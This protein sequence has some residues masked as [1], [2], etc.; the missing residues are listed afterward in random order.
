VTQVG[1]GHGAESR[2]V[3]TFGA[4][5]VGEILA[6]RYQL[7]EHINNDATGRQVWRGV[8][9]ILRRPVAVVLRYP[10]GEAAVEMLDAAVAAS[11]VTH[12]N[13]VGVY[14]AIDEGDRAYV[15]REWVDGAAL[16]DYVAQTP[17]DAAR[18][19]TVAHAV[20]AA[21][22]AVHSTGMVHGN[23]H[24]GTVLIG[25]DGRVVLADARAEGDLDPEQDIRATGAVLY[26][27]LTGH[28]PQVEAGRQKLPDAVRDANGMLASPRRVRA[29]VPTY[30]DELVT[31]LLDLRVAAPSADLLAAELGRLDA[32]S[33][34]DGALEP[35][36][37]DDQESPLGF[38]A[39]P[40]AEPPRRA[41]RKVAIGVIALLLVAAVGLYVG[42]RFL[43]AT[44]ADGSPTTNGQP[45]AG[46][47]QTAAAGSEVIKLSADQVR[48]VDPGGDRTELGGVSAAIDGNL[49]T[50]W[51][52]QRYR[53]NPKFGGLK[54]GMG[55][56]INLKE[57]RKVSVE[58]TLSAPGASA[59][60]RTGTA[61][62]PPTKAGD[63]Q[64]VAAYQVGTV[65]PTELTNHGIKMVFEVSDPAQ[66]LLFWITSMPKADDGQYQIG[67]QEIVLHAR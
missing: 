41:G 11:R 35:G 13:L 16:R 36:Y 44:G 53:N 8:D 66:Y 2:P 17:L 58:I 9:V 59:Q 43:T 30:L 39:I 47:N 64:I 57:P 5:A 28:W 3:M 51:K 32:Q 56:L 52:T 12:S 34:V 19:T 54:P 22:A 26:F 7:E 55:I 60:L 37:Y 6:D 61:D 10:G 29:G 27:A 40:S 62:A 33:E 65:T 15:V 25:T 45:T 49:D 38:G 20:A 23:I 21:V 14:D 24:P 4:P 50:G 1:E 48:V 42:V 67:V 46:A 63:E 31:D 18:A